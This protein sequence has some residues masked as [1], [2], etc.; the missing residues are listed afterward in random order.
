MIATAVPKPKKKAARYTPARVD[1]PL[2]KTFSDAA[3]P[4][5]EWF[6]DEYEPLGLRRRD[7]IVERVDGRFQLLFRAEDRCKPDRWALLDPEVARQVIGHRR[8][9]K[10]DYAWALNAHRLQRRFPLCFPPLLR[11]DERE[12]YEA[13]GLPAPTP[14]H[15]LRE[16]FWQ[17]SRDLAGPERPGVF[18]YCYE[19]LHDWAA[20]AMQGSAPGDLLV[21][22]TMGSSEPSLYGKVTEVALPALR[23]ELW[24]KEA[25]NKTA[26][27]YLHSRFTPLTHSTPYGAVDPLTNFLADYRRWP[28]KPRLW[29]VHR[30]N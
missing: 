27:G 17:R 16:A 24:D 26:W 8:P 25:D 15:E 21:L 19:K 18:M 11:Q 12:A 1:W 5:R 2:Y 3:E 20:S 22:A 29:I 4:F 28:R 23:A 13:L 10:W 7:A 14:F 6:G 30:E 9:E